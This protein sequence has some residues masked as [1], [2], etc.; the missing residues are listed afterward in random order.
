MRQPLWGM[1]AIVLGLAVR[2][3]N[4]ESFPVGDVFAPLVADPLE[5]RS[6][7]SMLGLD[8]ESRSGGSTIGSVGVGASLGFYRW[9]G[10]RPDDGWQIGIFAAVASQFD[11]EADSSPLLNADY[12]VGFPLSFRRGEW[13]GRARLFHQS[14]HLG[15]EF[16]LEGSAPPRINLSAEA[17]DFVLAW[18]RSGWRPYVGGTYL[19]HTELG[20]I[21]KAGVQAGIDYLGTRAMLAGGRLVGG[22]DYRAFEANDWRHGLS[23]KVGLE[24]GRPRP[25]RRG[26][27]VLLEAYDGFA[28]FGQFFRTDISYYGVALQFDY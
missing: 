9:R 18:E 8:A 3:A 13:S 15:D 23:F 12:R 4:A 1:L 7:I 26:I 21:G 10:E 20:G 6:F 28:P 25:E 2:G 19:L 5:T 11:L 24:F 17:V 27:T 22:I 16:I 14:S